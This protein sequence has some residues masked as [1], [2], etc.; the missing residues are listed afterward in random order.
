[1]AGCSN[2][3]HLAQLQESSG[4]ADPVDS[5][6][7]L[8]APELR[9]CFHICEALLLLFYHCCPSLARCQEISNLLPSFCNFLWL[10][11]L[12][13]FEPAK[14]KQIN[15]T[16]CPT[17]SFEMQA[18]LHGSNVKEPDAMRVES[19]VWKST[20]TVLQAL[21]GE[22]NQHGQLCTCTR[23]AISQNSIKSHSG[24]YMFD[25]QKPVPRRKIH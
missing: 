14:S 9:W 4:Q 16:E 8:D 1:M 18:K 13:E 20:T 22:P 24:H 21:A 15:S 5:G 25:R 6:E 3:S 7:E 11:S 23:D 19:K 2:N 12:L 10:A 17:T